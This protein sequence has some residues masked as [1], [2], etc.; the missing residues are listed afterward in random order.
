MT[1]P[2]NQPA[3]PLLDRLRTGYYI[4]FPHL[5]HGSFNFLEGFLP[6]L[7]G[8]R[9]VQRWSRAGPEGIAGYEAIGR[10]LLRLARH[11]VTQGRLPRMAPLPVTSGLPAGVAAV[12]RR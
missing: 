3:P 11:H 9:Q 4:E 12:D 8:I 5:A 10:I 2:R 1:Q 6:S 7:V